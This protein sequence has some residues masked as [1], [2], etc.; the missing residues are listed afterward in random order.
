MIVDDEKNIR[1]LLKQELEYLGYN[2]IEAVN[3]IEALSIINKNHIDLIILDVMMPEMNGF[4]VA[5]TLR[6]DPFTISI[7]II[8]LTIVE[9]EKRGLEIGVDNYQHKPIQPSI[10][11]PKISEIL[12]KKVSKKNI[13]ILHED[14]E[15][16]G[17]LVKLFLSIGHSSSYLN[18]K[19]PNILEELT[20]S[21]YELVIMDHKTSEFLEIEEKIHREP[22]LKNLLVYITYSE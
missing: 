19:K 16:S 8:I 11:L 15:E 18:P 6:T 21:K 17:K 12:G 5:S 3:G 7:P 20:N 14:E 22:A 9:D 1:D 10:L 2:T 4:D 13:L